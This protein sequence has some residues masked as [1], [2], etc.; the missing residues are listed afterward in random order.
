MN[1]IIINADDFGLNESR[2]KA[3]YEAYNKGLITDTTLVANGDAYEQAINI[4]CHDKDFLKR[5]GVHFNLTDCTPLTNEMKNYKRFTDNGKFNRFFIK[6]N[7]SFIHL[8]KYEKKIIYNELT[9]QIKKIQ[10]SGVDVS[11][12][13]SHHHVH[14]GFKL[15][16]IFVRVCKENNITK[17]RPRKNV[18]KMSL[19]RRLFYAFYNLYLRMNGFTLVNYFGDAKEYTKVLPGVCEAMVHPDYEDGNLIDAMSNKSLILYEPEI[20]CDKSKHITYFDL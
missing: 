11:H 13:D 2:T 20:I 8:D 1:R 3:I 9:A 14:M 16:P 5:I 18:V 10:E 7:S 12:A 6:K 19:C 15:A 17:I 4:L